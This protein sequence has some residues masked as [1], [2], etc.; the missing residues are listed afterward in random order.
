MLE[1]KAAWYR[2]KQFDLKDEISCEK[3]ATMIDKVSVDREF[4]GMESRKRDL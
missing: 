2:R 4:L 3:E 1:E